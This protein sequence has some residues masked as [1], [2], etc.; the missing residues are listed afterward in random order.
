MPSS[1]PPRAWLGAAALL[2]VLAIAGLTAERYRIDSTVD[3]LERFDQPD[4]PVRGIS[5]ESR[6]LDGSTRR[7]LVTKR[8][9][10]VLRDVPVF[11]GAVLQFSVGV[12]DSDWDR[13]GDSVGFK[14][15]AKYGK[16]KQLLYTRYLDPKQRTADQRWIDVEL[17][18]SEILSDEVERPSE[19]DLIL[20][21]T[22][23]FRGD[24]RHD[25]GMW[26]DVRVARA[27]WVWPWLREPVRPN[28]VLI[29]I[30]TLR[31]DRIGAVVRGRSITPNLDELGARG[32]RFERAYAPANHTL[33]SHMSLLTGLY[34]KTHGVDRGS[35]KHGNVGVKGLP[36]PRVTLAETLQAHGYATGGFVFSC[37][38]LDERFG[39][40]QG[41]DH[42]KVISQGAAAA[43]QREILPWLEAHRRKPFF[44]FVHFYDVHS[45]WSRLPYDAPPEILARHRE[46]Y[47]GGFDGCDENRL[48][49]TRYLKKLDASG[50]PLAEQDLAYIRSLYD[51]GVEATDLQV[52]R[53]LERLAELGVMENTLVIVTSD[54]GEEFREH[55]RFIHSQ[56]Y[57]EIA[58]V[59]LVMRLPSGEHAG[60]SSTHPV[61]L[62][63]VMPTVLDLLRIEAKDPIEGRSLLPLMRGGRVEPDPIFITSRT[64]N[65]VIEW[66][67]KLIQGVDGEELYDL[68]S[69]PGETRNLSGSE[70]ERA[71][72][73]RETMTR[74]RRGGEIDRAA[75]PA[76]LIETDEA[77]LERLRALGY[78]D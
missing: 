13:A 75:E 29:S 74:W 21:T 54:H 52:G 16:R 63:D 77:D 66:P 28:V 37:V 70:V 34:P 62:L 8:R 57:E 11:D 45:D 5:V 64:A 40:A 44:L 3:L 7:A 36:D 17:P 23:G 73:M 76:P 33:L 46:G 55:G 71:T 49:A 60:G 43:N 2:V 39:F 65:S 12:D 53:L 14:L 9:R 18:F 72:R 15:R 51:A 35:G 68:A 4:R 22:P 25:G 41:F 78:A 58:R 10:V 67:W 31:A 47:R 24:E 61:E 26:A 56:I 50:E 6:S 32:F 59:P 38:W 19:V 30:D 42:Y 69:D 1:R 48:C 20:S 27:G